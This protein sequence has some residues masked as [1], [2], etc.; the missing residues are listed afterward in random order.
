MLCYAMM[1]VS[2]EQYIMM[3]KSCGCQCGLSW[4]HMLSCALIFV[5]AGHCILM[6]KTV[7][8]SV[9]VCAD[10]K[11]NKIVIWYVGYTLKCCMVCWE[12]GGI[13]YNVI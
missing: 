5:S 12:S 1:C 8:V 9:A 4:L 2:A 7:C 11:F 10:I 13:Q 6:F 3:F